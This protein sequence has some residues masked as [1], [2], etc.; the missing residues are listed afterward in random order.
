MAKIDTS[1]FRTGMV[2]EVDDEL[3]AIVDYQHVKPGKGGAFVRTK[4]KGVVSE[5]TIEK[6]F[7]YF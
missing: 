6:I 3:Y 1:D 7:R 2:I 4:M 5:K